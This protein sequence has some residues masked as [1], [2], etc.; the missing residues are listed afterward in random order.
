MSGVHRLS[1]HLKFHLSDAAKVARA[2]PQLCDI[3]K[4]LA[5]AADDM[6]LVSLHAHHFHNPP[7]LCVAWN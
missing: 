5:S 6:T 4:L 7:L 1:Q 3:E 2:Y